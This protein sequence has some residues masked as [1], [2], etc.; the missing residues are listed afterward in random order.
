MRE[1]LAVFLPEVIAKVIML[2]AHLNLVSSVRSVRGV[3]RDE[4]T[5]LG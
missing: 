3:L 5:A 1:G 2:Q 4:C